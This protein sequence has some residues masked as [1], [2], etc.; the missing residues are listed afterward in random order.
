MI[1]LIV[2]SQ[3]ALLAGIGAAALPILIHLLLRPRPRRTRFPA[4]GLLRRVL[5]TG[6]RANRLRN[7]TLLLVRALLLGLVALL[8]AGPTC[9]PNA[10]QFVGAGPIACVA[11]LDDSAST[12]Y[13]VGRDTTR[14]ELSRTQAADFVRGSAA[15]PD[16]SVL[17]LLRARDDDA[18]A[19]FTAD[20]DVALAA[21]AATKTAPLHTSPLGRALQRAAGLL[22][23]AEHP[24]KRI[25][26]F[27]DGAAHAW[28]GTTPALL[29]GL[30][31]LAVRV[32]MP[33]GRQQSNLAV[34][35]A[36]GPSRLHP[37]T[38][39]IP[40][41]A[42][43]SAE[44]L[45]GQCWLLVRRGEDLL[46]RAGPF[47]I[48]ANTTREVTLELPA[49]PPGVHI[50]SVEIEP[51]DRL[52]FDQR[53]FVAFQTAAAPIVWLVAPADAAGTQDLSA[54]ILRNLL[55]PEVLPV[56]R[57][58]ARLVALD[59]ASLAAKLGASRE[60]RDAP[61]RIERPA[62]AVILSSVDIDPRAAATLL[63]HVENGTRVLLVPSSRGQA[64]D[65][66]ALR[67]M[68]ADGAPLEN[69]P[70]TPTG[71]H[72]EP[73]SEYAEDRDLGELTRCVAR[74]RLL[75]G[76]L[77][78]D[79]VVH[80]RYADGEPALL[81]RPYGAGGLTL[82]TTS[83]DPEWSELGIRAAGLLTWLH[84]LIDESA[85]PPDASAAFALGQQTRRRFDALPPQ[86]LVSIALPTG[87]GDE[88]VWTRLSNGEPQRPWPTDRIGA[89]SVGAAGLAQRGSH[90]VVNAP[91]EE[92][93]LVPI[94]LPGL[95]HRLGMRQVQIDTP[96]NASATQRLSWLM[97]LLGA[98]DVRKSLAGLLL[99]VFLLEL[100]LTARRGRYVRTGETPASDVL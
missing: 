53:R 32:V 4:V 61:S 8:L 28:E 23:S 16:G 49:E 46:T 69:I 42:T 39:P 77:H 90:Y 36:A 72:W 97:R 7:L 1:G 80:A 64:Q 95:R 62:L 78:K 11:I 86:S 79:V 19:A 20:R 29:A 10:A 68:F 56:E 55:A 51:E 74:R 63:Q 94:E 98:S 24:G 47:T 6:Q 3:P 85:G 83:P 13:R 96:A 5:I 37:A 60:A 81:S 26:V 99:V 52:D 65:W 88:P 17:A 57:Q 31:D 45:D 35:A 14:L 89:Y 70:A 48:P 84:Q 58:L 67:H 66:P 25:V 82:L 100:L 59:S 92:S 2:F 18:T 9:T 22:R 44:G 75:F 93:R 50:V 43:I 41:R 87:G 12:G 30:D 40:I 91:A 71:L 34:I 76:D 15:W 54:L 27:T 21:I 73:A 33:P 38:A